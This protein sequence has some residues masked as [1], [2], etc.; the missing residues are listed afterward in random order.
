[1]LGCRSGDGV[2]PVL[3]SSDGAVQ[4]PRRGNFRDGNAVG[5]GRSSF[6]KNECYRLNV[7]AIIKP[8][9]SFHF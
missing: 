1:M 8:L 3:R 6:G 4:V 2:I 7:W 9:A 5:E